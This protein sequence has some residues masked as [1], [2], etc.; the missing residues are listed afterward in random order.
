M[1]SLA[2]RGQHI[3]LAQ[4]GDARG[5]G[6]PPPNRPS[7]S[8]SCGFQS[9]VLR[10][11]DFGA[12]EPSSRGR[13]NAYS[14]SNVIRRGTEKWLSRTGGLRPDSATTHKVLEPPCFRIQASIPRV[15]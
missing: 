2:L 12:I 9:A 1:K 8:T 10:A 4:L 3:N 6:F 11:A 13:P 7:G 14:C 5:L 15:A